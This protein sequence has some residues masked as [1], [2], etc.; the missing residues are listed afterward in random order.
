MLL[1]ATGR[2]RAGDDLGAVVEALLSVERALL[3]REALADHLRV[4]VD[5]DA[6]RPPPASFTT[7]TAASVRPG[8]GV[9]LRPLPASSSRPFS[10]FV[11]SSRTTTGTLTS[12]CF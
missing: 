8:A 7:L 4:F 3:A 9:I 5:Q 2:R 10:T 1:A 12:T 6:H 11:P